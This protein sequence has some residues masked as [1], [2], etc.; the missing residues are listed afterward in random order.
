[1]P[2]VFFCPFYDYLAAHPLSHH[3]EKLPEDSPMRWL[4]SL[5]LLLAVA[6]APPARAQVTSREGIQLQNEILELRHQ[7]QLLQGGRGGGGSSLGTSEPAPPAAAQGGGG[8]LVAQLLDRVSRLEDEVRTLRG[9]LDEISNRSQQA[10]ADLNKKIDDLQFQLTQGQGAKGGAVAAVPAA[11]PAAP[12][13]PAAPAHPTPEVA[14]SRG[15]A[16]LA[17]RD[18]ATAEAMA[19]EVLATAP[20]SP[21]AVDAQ[22]LLA[23]A[24]AGKRDNRGAALAYDDAYRKAPK[25]PRAEDSLLGLA[26]SLTAIG[27]KKAACET[28]NALHAQFPALRPD[29]RQPVVHAAQQA[30]CA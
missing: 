25:G 28:L 27:Q 3:V 14:L 20:K 8:N 18:Y 17:R 30:G 23:E 22:F 1:M 19:R 11:K 12:A 21:R 13:A 26:N 10:E 16:A 24:L 4:I 9:R 6:A 5:A 2:P 29:L 7:L 15:N